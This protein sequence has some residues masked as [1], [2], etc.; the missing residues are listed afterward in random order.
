MQAAHNLE[1][2][3]LDRSMHKTSLLLFPPLLPCPGRALSLSSHPVSTPTATSSNLEMFKLHLVS[4]SVTAFGRLPNLKLHSK[5]TQ[6]TDTYSS[7]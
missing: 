1:P 4:L 7:L 6:A 2:C 5:I 3:D